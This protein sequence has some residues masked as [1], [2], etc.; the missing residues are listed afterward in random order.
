[1]EE[2]KKERRKVKIKSSEKV[3]LVKSLF[4]LAVPDNVWVIKNTSTII[5]YHSYGGLTPFF[6][7]LTEGKLLG[8]KCSARLCKKTGIWLPPRVHCPDCWKEMKWTPIDTMEAKVY[9]HSVTNFPGAGFKMT[10]P[11]PL[12]SIEIP[13]ILCTKPMSYLMEFGEGEPYIEMKI[14]PVFRTDSPTYTILDVGWVP[15]TES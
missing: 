6:K 14:R 7:G 4:G 12:I 11:C 10:A 9:T 3:E 13:G 15:L 1:M 5:H 8:T 2:I